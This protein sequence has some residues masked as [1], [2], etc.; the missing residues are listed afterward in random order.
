MFLIFKLLLG[1]A[2]TFPMIGSPHVLA[3]IPA[4]QD[5]FADYVSEA[6]GASRQKAKDPI[7]AAIRL[8]TG[9][10]KVITTIIGA[11]HEG[12]KEKMFKFMEQGS[13]KIGESSGESRAEQVGQSSGESRADPPVLTDTEDDEEVG[14]LQAAPPA[15]ETREEARQA[16]KAMKALAE[17]AEAQAAQEAED[18]QAAEDVQ[19][20][21]EAA[22]K[23]QAAK[24]AQYKAAKEAES[25]MAQG[26]ERA[27]RIAEADDAYALQSAEGV[28]RAVPQIVQ[29]RAA[30]AKVVIDLSLD[31]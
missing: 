29:A 15:N 26:R 10:T 9:I 14:E 7:S 1:S 3:Q 23:A 2:F 4:V 8:Q 12:D 18:A 24:E 30:P 13:Q 27:R 19:A 5:E 20:A 28:R 16:R 17:A 25:A 22:E 11:M 21:K 6:I 31:D